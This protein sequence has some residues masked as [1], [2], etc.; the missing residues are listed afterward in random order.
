M[1]YKTNDATP[2]KKAQAASITRTQAVT[3]ALATLGKDAMPM[4]ITGFIKDKFGI[5]MSNNAISAYKSEINRK[6]EKTNPASKRPTLK[7]VVKQATAPIAKKPTPAPAAHKP[8]TSPKPQA[9]PVLATGSNG[10]AGVV[11]LD[12]IR[13]VKALVGKVG[14]DNLKTLID[15]ISK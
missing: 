10:K 2:S 7:P 1:T 8:V 11:G 4:Q 12:E 6:A 15:L 5:E 14:A 3:K 9:K 13:A